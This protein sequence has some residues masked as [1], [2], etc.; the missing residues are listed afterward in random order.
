ME[1]HLRRLKLENKKKSTELTLEKADNYFVEK[2]GIPPQELSIIKKQIAPGISDGDLLYCLDFSKSTGLSIINKEM[3][4]VPR[5]SNVK[6]KAVEKHEPMAGRRGARKIARSKGMDLPPETHCEIKMTPRLVKGN[7]EMVEDL[8]AIAEL[9][10]KD[11]NG[12]EHKYTQEA[13]YSSFVQTRKSGEV[14]KF[15]RTMPTVMLEKVAEFQLLDA[16]YGLN[17]VQNIDTGT[18]ED[19]M[20]DGKGNIVNSMMPEEKTVE[21]ITP[22]DAL[23]EVINKATDLPKEMKSTLSSKQEEV[24]KAFADADIKGLA[25]I[26]QAL[27]AN[28]ATLTDKECDMVLRRNQ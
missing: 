26:N 2:M 24:E 27:G 3:Y 20:Q 18:V 11:K 8:V 9:T 14:T 15:W 25:E 4:I 6:G 5:W 13:A 19:E 22:V 10:I 28:L 17:G 23:D 1:T 12:E 21:P 16:V 7:W